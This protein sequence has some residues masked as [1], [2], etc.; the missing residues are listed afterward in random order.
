MKDLIGSGAGNGGDALLP[1]LV[2]FV[3]FVLSGSILTSVR[4]FFFGANLIAIQK[5][6]GGIRPIAVGCTLRRLV[7]KVAGMK[8]VDEMAALL[9]PRQLGYGVKNGAEAAVHTARL[10]FSNLN[11]NTAI[12]KLDFQNA[13]NS[14]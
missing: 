1:A 14:I 8:V 4:P 13:F 12:L 9:A 5:K 7:A 6:G 2:S 10:Y 11:P 3:E